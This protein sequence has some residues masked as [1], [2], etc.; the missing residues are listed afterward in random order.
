MKEHVTGLR[1]NCALLCYQNFSREIK[2]TNAMIITQFEIFF[3]YSL[4]EKELVK[5][6][7]TRKSLLRY[8]ERH[9]SIKS[10]QVS[11]KFICNSYTTKNQYR[12]PSYSCV[13]FF[14]FIGRRTQ[15][16]VDKYKVIFSHSHSM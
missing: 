7:E 11:L 5:M 10:L 8:I 4:R 14:C 15:S 12:V 6:I 3:L 13:V 16:K 9:F 2:H 1:R